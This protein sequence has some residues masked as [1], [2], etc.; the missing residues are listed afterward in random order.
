M[1]RAMRRVKQ[2]L[3]RETAMEI[4]QKNTSGTLALLGDEDYPYAVPLSYVYSDGKLYFHSASTGHKIDAVAH[5][6]KASFCVIDQDL[7]VPE[8]YTTLFRS[9]IAF[10]RAG[11][12][13]NAEEKRQAITALAMK[14][15]P[16]F[17]DGI[18]PEVAASLDHMAIVEMTVEH[19]TGKEA[20][21]LA[22]QRGSL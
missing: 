10:G 3:S 13:E 9:V 22:A 16:D 21:A 14:Y 1:F 20:K 5:H 12:V 19:L 7:I 6:E 17:P 18:G 15:A 8:K 11:L 2:Q 4:L